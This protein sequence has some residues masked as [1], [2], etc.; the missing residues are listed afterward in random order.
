MAEIYVRLPEELKRV[1]LKSLVDKEVQEVGDWC[2][3]MR[4]L[5][6]RVDKRDSKDR[7]EEIAYKFCE[8]VVDD[9][10]GICLNKKYYHWRVWGEGDGI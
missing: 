2:W 4:E 5:L 10:V 9:E 6:M 3:D 1:V 7:A 8:M